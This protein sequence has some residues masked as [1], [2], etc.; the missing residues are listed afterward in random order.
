MRNIS[1]RKLMSH[2]SLFASA[3]C[4]KVHFWLFEKWLIFFTVKYCK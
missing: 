3:S 1:K 4:N 2:N